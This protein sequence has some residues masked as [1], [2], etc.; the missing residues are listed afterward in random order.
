MKKDKKDN[1]EKFSKNNLEKVAKGIQNDLGDDMAV[2]VFVGKKF[3][4]D[5]PEFVMMFQSA[6]K[7]LFK[8]LSPGACKVIG[9]MFSIL[10][11]SNHIGTDQK[12]LSEELSLSVRTVNGAIKELKDKSV[13][14][15]YRDPQDTRRQIYMINPH[16]AWKGKIQNR[17]KHIKA[18]PLQVDLYSEIKEA[19]RREKLSNLS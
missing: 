3:P 11:Y 15:S 9:Y 5:V 17:Q 4:K 2:S 10:Q 19:E 7:S 12:T 18:N 16:A 14:I 13:I 8:T 1:T 6:G